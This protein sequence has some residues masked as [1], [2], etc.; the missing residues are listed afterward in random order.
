[1]LTK[2]SNAD[3]DTEWDTP[4]P[5]GGG[6]LEV[7]DD[8]L[9]KGPASS[10]D[11][12]TGLSV[13]YD[14]PAGQARIDVEPNA[15]NGLVQDLLDNVDWP[16]TTATRAEVGQTTV[17]RFWRSDRGRVPF[18][19][20]TLPRGGRR[21][22]LPISATSFTKTG[23][24]TLA[25]STSD[26]L[27]YDRV[28]TLTTGTSPSTIRPTA[29]L[30]P[31]DLTRG[32]IRAIVRLGPTW[33]SAG[34][35]PLYLQVSSDNFTT[36]NYHQVIV[37]RTNDPLLYDNRWGVISENYNEFAPV[38]LGADLTAVNQWR[39]QIAAASGTTLTLAVG[40]VEFVPA[41]MPRAL[42]VIGVDDATAGMWQDM[43]R[44]MALNGLPP[45]L[46]TNIGSSSQNPVTSVS[47]AGLRT[48]HDFLGA[49]IATHAFAD[50][51]HNS[52]VFGDAL[53][54]WHMRAM[55]LRKALGFY[56]AED[57]SYYGG[58]NIGFHFQTDD[59]YKLARKLYATCR[60]NFNH[61]TTVETL[62]LADP[63]NTRSYLLASDDTMDPG[64]QLV[65]YIDKGIEGK[66]L[67]EIS[68]HN[69]N[70]GAT[71]GA[72]TAAMCQY[73]AQK[74]AEGVVDVVTKGEAMR[75]LAL[76]PE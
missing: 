28:V 13:T 14:V 37:T 58:T 36:G 51:D 6:A 35:Q 29:A 43:V 49:Q 3:Y 66:G 41:V 38:G 76:I 39:M 71:G 20:G 53:H 32:M 67:I 11:F 10:I 34:N 54:Q 4:T 7:L 48:A 23:S 47:Y 70:W 33:F 50:A 31:Y 44:V 26:P 75:R 16:I 17:G 46:Y 15:G 25:E 73:L 62:P 18:T 22:S 21:L 30:T 55:A 74:Q 59:H 52:A 64:S 27:V 8:G 68:S 19:A 56:G 45:T 65:T 12:G 60:G 42:C 1:M 5:G 9:D 61:L 57:A 24:G 40:L 63:W 72:V 69:G 2:A